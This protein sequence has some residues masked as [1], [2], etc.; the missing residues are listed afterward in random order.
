MAL[1][2]FPARPVRLPPGHTRAAPPAWVTAEL[3]LCGYAHQLTRL[4]E[5]VDRGP[6]RIDDM[7]ATRKH[8]AGI[9]LGNPPDDDARPARTLADLER[10]I[11][12]R[13]NGPH[14]SE[15]A[16][17]RRITPR[18]MRP[19]YAALDLIWETNRRADGAARR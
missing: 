15:T 13:R 18:E 3:C 10:E 16:R 14:A 12:A 17:R 8:A 6:Q 7:R 2:P 19:S 11:Y 5:R 1:P 9:P 4:F